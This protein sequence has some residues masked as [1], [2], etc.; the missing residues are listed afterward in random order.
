MKTE[1]IN[2]TTAEPCVVVLHWFSVNTMCSCT[3]F[4]T[5][6]VW[7]GPSLGIE[8]W[9]SRTQT[10]TLPLSYRGGGW[11]KIY[12]LI[13][14][15]YNCPIF[16]VLKWFFFWNFRKIFYPTEKTKAQIFCLLPSCVLIVGTDSFYSCC[17]EG[18]GEQWIWSGECTLVESVLA[19]S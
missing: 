10:S 18:L 11:T 16:T 3:I 4:I 7:R 6:L 12:M 14:Q 13:K 8:P 19:T 2:V 9:T 17:C 15:I 1:I 5:S